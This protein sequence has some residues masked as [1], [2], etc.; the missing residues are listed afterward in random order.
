MHWTTL[1]WGIFSSK[2]FTSLWHRRCTARTSAHSIIPTAAH[3]TNS[4]TSYAASTCQA[5][6]DAAGWAQQLRLAATTAAVSPCS[7][8]S[9]QFL[10]LL[11]QDTPGSPSLAQQEANKQQLILA[12]AATTV[13]RD[14]T[15]SYGKVGPAVTCIHSDRSACNC[16]RLRLC[17]WTTAACGAALRCAHLL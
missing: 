12:D 3:Q 6:S 11:L 17:R 5:D 9:L 4:F 7:S 13:Q 15:M 1:D 2:T 14:Q 16:L 10:A 8:L